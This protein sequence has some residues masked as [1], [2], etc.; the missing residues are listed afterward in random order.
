MRSNA[1]SERSERLHLKYLT[2][3]TSDPV[4]IGGFWGALLEASF[5]NN[6][7]AAWVVPSRDWRLLFLSVPESKTAKN[8]CHPDLATTDVLRHVKRAIEL[9][10]TEMVDYLD[11]FKFV[12]LQD[13]DGNEFCI[14]EYDDVGEG[15][16]FH[17]PTFDTADPMLIARFWAE[18]V[19]G[20]VRDHWLGAQVMPPSGRRML[21]ARV[22]EPK[23][24]K[25]R[26][27]PDYHTQNL[28]V[29]VE[30]VKA[31]GAI[32]TGRFHEVSPFVVFQDPDGNEFCIVEDEHPDP[33]G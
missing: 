32:E 5:D 21:F 15:L 6:D 3:D 13:P 28:D 29:E 22:P 14:V 33:N 10:A 20:E 18:V 2:F 4:A 24:A 26:C 11:D 9:G 17:G 23:T 30:R 7:K 8:R 16:S 1:V 31:L 12:V 25:N 27:H 19:G